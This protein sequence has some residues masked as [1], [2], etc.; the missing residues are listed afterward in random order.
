MSSVL[1]RDVRPYGGDPIDVLVRDGVVE[2][3]G[4]ALE[5]AGL[6]VHDGRGG[7]LLPGLV[8]AHAHLDKT[9]WGLPWRPHSATPGLAG[10]IE[11]ERRHRAELPPVAER[12]EGLLRAYV[13]NGTTAIRTHVDVDPELGLASVEGVWAARDALGGAIDVQVV[14]FPQAGLLT[15]PGT[16]ELLE[17]ALRQGVEVVGGIDPG[18]YDGDPVAH[19]DLVFGLAE[20]HGA[21]LDLHL[22]DRGE[23][24]A[25]EAE[26]TLE[27]TRALGLDGRVTISHAFFLGTVPEQRARELL[28]RIADLRISLATVAPGSAPVP[29][30]RDCH[31][32]GIAVGLGCDGIRDLWNP[33]GVPDLLERAML[34]AW[35]SGLRED[36]DLAL[37]L[38]AATTGGARIL[39]R[40]G[41]GVE[42]GCAAD[43]V[44][45]PA[46]T[47]GDAIM[48]RP[49][50]SLVLRRGVVV[51]GSTL[52]R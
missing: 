49:P 43:L 39:A 48:R 25:W 26:L 5:A 47:V 4:T 45:L 41:Y 34:L 10:L 12:A 13:D 20:R 6:D 24:G 27:R 52:P 46:E 37:A 8:D 32:L 51:G 35:R 15:R 30:L 29:P 2:R 14:A 7:L 23:L 16:A 19:L 22:H 9:L 42:P 1:L 18:G 40:A 31:D 21:E 50:R 38:E 3:V 17:E 28:E 36:G 44:V 33:F 11:N